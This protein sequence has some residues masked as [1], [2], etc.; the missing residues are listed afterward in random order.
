V[1]KENFHRAALGL[2][3][4]NTV[5][6]QKVCARYSLRANGGYLAQIALEHALLP[7]NPGAAELVERQVR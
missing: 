4:H 7:Y 3:R 5:S 2:A 1:G 6:S